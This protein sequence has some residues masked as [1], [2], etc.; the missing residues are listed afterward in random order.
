MSGTNYEQ[1]IRLGLVGYDGF[2]KAF[3]RLLRRVPSKKRKLLLG[4]MYALA[5]KKVASEGLNRGIEYQATVL[6]ERRMAL[7]RTRAQTK[8]ARRELSAANA[9]FPDG[10][11]GALDF[12]GIIEKL[13][14][15]E[16]DLA[17]REQGLAS[18]VHRKLKTKAERDIPAPSILKSVRLARPFPWMNVKV[19]DRWFVRAMD[20]CL[21]QPPRGHRLRFGRDNVIQKVFEV[22]GQPCS[23]KRIRAIR[24][25]AKLKRTL[26]VQET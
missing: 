20:K 16:K 22:L 25:Q 6:R 17:E 4:K 9:S 24:K 12:Q 11:P 10:L 19:I 7:A 23:T 5:A 18:L 13:V 8:N 1:A 3:E 26:E 21:G 2:E 15:F 14:E